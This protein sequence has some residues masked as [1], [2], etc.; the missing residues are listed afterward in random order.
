MVTQNRCKVRAS[1][2][3]Y[4]KNGEKKLV[5]S[6]PKLNRMLLLYV[7]LKTLTNAFFF[8]HLFFRIYILLKGGK[9][10]NVYHCIYFNAIL[11]EILGEKTKIN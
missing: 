6:L 2:Q 5:S 8:Y 11:E 7:C 4:S 9:I 10:T 3:K 1:H